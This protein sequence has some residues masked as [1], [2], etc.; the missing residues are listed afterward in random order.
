MA[1]EGGAFTL[2]LRTQG[3]RQESQEAVT[4]SLLRV[5]VWYRG[6]DVQV[7]VQSPAGGGKSTGEVGQVAGTAPHSLQ[8]QPVAALQILM[9]NGAQPIGSAS[10]RG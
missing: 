4:G 2:S 9:R 7:P 5:R 3:D 10:E 8:V 1:A 6:S